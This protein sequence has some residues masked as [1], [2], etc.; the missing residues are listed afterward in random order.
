MDLQKRPGIAETLDWTAA[1]LRL[2]VSTIDE[3]GAERILE[4]LS[5]LVKTRTDR[6]LL[7]RE[8]V[9][10]LAAACRAVRGNRVLLLLRLLLDR[11][12]RE[13]REVRG[14]PSGVRSARSGLNRIRRVPRVDDGAHV[15]RIATSADRYLVQRH[16]ARSETRAAAH[17]FRNQCFAV[18]LLRQVL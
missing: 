11:F 5:A 18:E 17:V 8:V 9:T 15:D 1:L 13:S 12:P 2:G 14:D 3:N 4:S 7:T 10:R 16:R 6:A